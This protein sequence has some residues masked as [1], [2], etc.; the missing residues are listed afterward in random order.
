MFQSPRWGGFM[1]DS[2]SARSLC[3]LPVVLVLMFAAFLFSPA[4]LAQ[5]NTGKITGIVTDSGGA[6]IANATVRATNQ[7]TSIGTT[8]QTQDNG[9][10]LVNFLIPGSYTVEASSAGFKTSLEKNVEVTAGGV[11]RIDF[12]M[13]IGEI[14]QSVEV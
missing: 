1:S 6:V 7:A 4:A 13:Q 12:A 2:C 5:I 3:Q 11:N 14:R 9:S 8:V 10:F